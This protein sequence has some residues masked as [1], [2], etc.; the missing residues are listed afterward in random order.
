MKDN[1]SYSTLQI[2]TLVILRLVIGWHILYEGIA[3]LLNP[4]WS[5]IG[6]LSESKWILSGFANWIISN[7]GV[8][9]TVDFLNT[10]GL[11]AIGAALML[12]IF[13]R[14]AVVAGTILLLIYY[15]NNPPLIGLEYSIPSEGSNII[16]NKT[17]IEA[18]A[19][20]LLAVFPAH[21]VY[22]LES[23]FTKKLKKK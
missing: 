7:P 12:G 21:A 19:L 1:N 6:F 23:L 15:L 9:K 16:V 3:K 14:F 11:I 8:L 18:I 2:T 13:M 22:G 10:W 5:S 4:N 17:L 20:F